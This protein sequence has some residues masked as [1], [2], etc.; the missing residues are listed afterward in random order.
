MYSNR[1]KCFIMKDNFNSV[2]RMNKRKIDFIKE[3]VNIISEK[4]IT[5]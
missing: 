1:G 3:S 5:Q 4:E 2:V